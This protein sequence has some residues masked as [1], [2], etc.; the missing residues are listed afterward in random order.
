VKKGLAGTGKVY[1][2]SGTAVPSEYSRVEYIEATGN[3]YI[4]TGVNP[5][6]PVKVEAEAECTANLSKGVWLPLLAASYNNGSNDSNFF[7]LWVWLTTISGNGYNRWMLI[8][9]DLTPFTS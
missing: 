9:N 5:T 7:G 6:P 3:Q 8:Y 2:S 1:A 4:D